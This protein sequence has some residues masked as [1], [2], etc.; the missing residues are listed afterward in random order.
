[1]IDRDDRPWVPLR[2]FDRSPPMGTVLTVDRLSFG[3]SGFPTS[4]DVHPMCGDVVRRSPNVWRRG[5]TFTQ[6]VETWSDVPP[7][8]ALCR[9]WKPGSCTLSAMEAWFLHAVGDG[10]LVLAR[11][12]RWKPGSCTLSAMIDRTS[13]QVPSRGD[14]CCSS[15]RRPHPEDCVA[16]RSPGGLIR[17]TALLL[18][19]MVTGDHCRLPLP[20][21]IFHLPGRNAIACPNA[22]RSHD[23][24]TGGCD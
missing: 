3:R 20:T 15:A 8:W 9:R 14:C 10:S 12:R 17:R 16:A 21:S 4:T 7:R 2:P 18:V 19:P 23:M 11:C 5:Q 22:M 13:N 1:V 6:R 24:V